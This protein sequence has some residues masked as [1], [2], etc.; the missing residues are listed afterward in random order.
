[1]YRCKR[2]LLQIVGLQVGLLVAWAL[3]AGVLPEERVD[4][5]YHYFDGG[6]VQIDGPSILL[7]KN[8]KDSV[9]VYGNYYIDSISSASIDVVTTG[10]S[11]YAEERNEYSVGMDFLHE[12][13]I[14][15]V[16][17]TNSDE[18]DYKAQSIN[19]GVAQEVF[20]GM[21]TVTMGFG[22]GSDQIYRNG[23][24][25]KPDGLFNDQAER[26]NY[27]LGVSQVV[28]QNILLGI[29]YEAIIDEGYLNNPYRQV[30][31]DDPNSA[32]GYSFQSEVYPRTRASNALALR[33]RYHLPYRAAVHGGYR[34]FTDSWGIDAQNIDVG[35]THPLKETWIFDVSYRYYAQ[36][37]ADFYSD[38][39]PYEDAQNFMGRDKEMSTFNSH[40][41]RFGVSYDLMADGW[42]F[43][44]NLT[45]NVYYDHILFE[46]KDFRDLRPVDDSGTPSGAPGSEPLYNF[47]ADVL[48]LYFSAWF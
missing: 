40:A 14:M 9:S 2:I 23:P 41:I 10:A 39:F 19:I 16:S 24:D 7:R 34:F 21:T 3:P 27:R 47:S 32:S 37:A 38:L 48:Q 8:I 45:M 35:Y 25:G 43:M 4:T 20:G 1:M 12:D 30:R 5:L 31:Y 33:A 46:Y 17:Y 42:R 44:Q 18:N 26:R 28:T 13:T 36:T 29:N 15:S 11:P 22:R 6:G